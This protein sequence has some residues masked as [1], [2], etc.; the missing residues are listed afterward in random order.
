MEIIQVYIY[1]KIQFSL[2]SS[3]DHL[4]S[5]RIRGGYGFQSVPIWIRSLDHLTDLELT[6]RMVGA[7]DL[8][9]FAGLPS[10]VRFQLTMKES[11]R[12]GI[13]I[14]ASRF[15]CLKEF[16]ISCRIMPVSFSQGVMPKL[17]KF[18]LQFRA[19]QEDLKFTRPAVV[20]LQSIKEFQFT[21]AVDR[22]LGDREVEHLK[23]SFKSAVFV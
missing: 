16:F 18:G 22:G 20:H 2:P 5:L 1:L 9:I 10:L 23:K 4:K 8:E 21:I 13:I 11:S 17:E 14:P 12:E 19:Y 3:P 7:Q 15:P 6:V